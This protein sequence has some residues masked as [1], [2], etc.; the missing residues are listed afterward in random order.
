MTN[1][2]EDEAM[3]AGLM[4]AAENRFGTAAVDK[5]VREMPAADANRAE[6]ARE[7]A[8]QRN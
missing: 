8:R 4:K 3:A 1:L 7:I 6:Q 5:V 2:S